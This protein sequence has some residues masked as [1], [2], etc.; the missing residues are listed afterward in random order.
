MVSP[1][2]HESSGH[3]RR[4]TSRES[5]PPQCPRRQPR[6]GRPWSACAVRS[7][8]SLDRHRSFSRERVRDSRWSVRPRIGQCWLDR[9]ANRLR[10]TICSRARRGVGLH[11]EVLDRV[12]GRDP[13]DGVRGVLGRQRV[14]LVQPSKLSR[15][16]GHREPQSRML[17]QNSRAASSH[18]G[19]A[20]QASC[21]PE[22]RDGSP[23]TSIWY[24]QTH[25]LVCFLA[26]VLW[27]TLEQSQRR[28]GLGNR[29]RK[30]PR[31][32]RPDPEHRR[33]AR[34]RRC[35][36][37]GVANPMRRSARQGAG[38]GARSPRSST[39]PTAPHPPH[40]SSKCSADFGP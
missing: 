32:D 39:P 34:A 23:R 26:Y 13:W 37:T 24:R 29:P 18:S 27:K 4:V 6:C 38:D 12:R 16:D 28:A 21:S 2:Q 10:G 17:A 31:E 30:D 14:E 15:E 1:G 8:R 11:P 7:A 36:G 35:A 40:T 25:I 33:D 19:F 3:D 9:Q 5:Q 22:S 20:S